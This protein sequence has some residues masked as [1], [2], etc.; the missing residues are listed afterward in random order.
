MLPAV[1]HGAGANVSV[2]DT[3]L[4]PPP[5]PAPTPTPYVNAAMP[6]MAAVT[7][8]AILVEAMPAN[9]LATPI[10]QTN[11]DQLGAL[12]PTIMGAATYTSPVPNVTMMNV[13][14]VTVTATTTA[15]N[16]NA[17]GT[18]V[19]SGVVAVKIA[20]RAGLEDASLDACRRLIKP[21]PGANAP[22][23]A[24]VRDGVATLR[25]TT[26]TSS[27]GAEVF[28]A[29]ERL[30][31][32]RELVVDLRGCPGGDVAAAFDLAE[33]FLPEGI[34]LGRIV[35][36]PDD[37]EVLYTRRDMPYRMPLTI[38]VDHQTASAAEVFAGCLQLHRRATIRGEHTYGK[39]KIHRVE[40]GHERGGALLVPAGDVWLSA[41]RRLDGVGLTPDVVGSS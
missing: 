29:L 27:I 7:A 16:M 18:V 39:G 11:G 40:A 9:N 30:G 23:D 38:L 8:P 5:V 33:D 21:F 19:A 26:F 17:M 37:L 6:T 24:D 14:A 22:V 12:H 36:A 25:I 1:N 3:C 2:P 35:S 15:N 13:P 10:L 31:S 4:T 32:P 41:E 34:E 20:R 28:A